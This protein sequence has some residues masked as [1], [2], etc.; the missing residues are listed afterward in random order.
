M[1]SWVCIRSCLH[2]LKNVFFLEVCKV[3]QLGC[4]APALIFLL[5]CSESFS[6]EHFFMDLRNRRFAS[7]A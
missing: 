4:G 5:W 6:P 7:E 1:G 3:L 2:S